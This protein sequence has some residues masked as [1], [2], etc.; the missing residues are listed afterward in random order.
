MLYI[1]SYNVTSIALKYD[2]HIVYNKDLPDSID[3]IVVDDGSF[4]LLNYSHQEPLKLKMITLNVE[5]LY[6]RIETYFGEYAGRN[7]GMYGYNATSYSMEQFTPYKAVTITFSYVLPQPLL[8]QRINQAKVKANQI[9]K[10][11]TKDVYMPP[12][13][14]VYLALSYLQQTVSYDQKAFEVIS[15]D[16]NLIIK[17]P[18]CQLAY[19]PLNEHLG[20]CTGIS[21]AFKYLMDAFHIE[22]SVICGSTDSSGVVN[23]AWN[24]VKINHQYF[25]VDVT[26]NIGEGVTIHKFMKD[27]K[28]MGEYQ[29][30]HDKYPKAIG[31]HYNYDFVENWL[32]ENGQKLIEAGIDKKYIYPYIIE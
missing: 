19:G 3:D 6:Q 1:Y 8:H 29:W 17:Y 18:H 16:S 22:C 25:H 2:I 13:I 12:A 27:D 5:D 14:K 24:L 11:L 31:I 20:I 4:T 21:H 10:E 30:D 26:Y 28:N 32:E 9:A 7:E 23:H 15:N